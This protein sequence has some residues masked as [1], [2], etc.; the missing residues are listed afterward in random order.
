MRA[1]VLAY[2]QA[3]TA[4]VLLGSPTV[5]DGTDP[6]AAA[7]QVAIAVCPLTVAVSRAWRR[8]RRWG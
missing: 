6:L 8:S 4:I 3:L 1:S 7:G 2:L 5:T